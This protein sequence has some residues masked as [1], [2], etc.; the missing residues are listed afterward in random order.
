[1]TH[2]TLEPRHTLCLLTLTAL[3]FFSAAAYA[4][5][6]LPMTAPSSMMQGQMQKSVDSSR[7]MMHSMKKNM[8]DMQKMPMSGDIDRDFA[9]M[10]KMHHSQAVEMAQMELAQGKSPEMKAMAQKIIT[11]QNHEIAQFDKWLAKQK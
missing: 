5:T 6:A 2:K 3:C 7:T 1:M 10:M 9:M 4:Q 8:D 11:D